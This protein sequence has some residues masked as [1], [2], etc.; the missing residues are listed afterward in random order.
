MQKGGQAKISTG[1]SVAH[2]VYRRMLTPNSVRFVL[3][4]RSHEFVLV[5]WRPLLERT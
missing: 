4:E 3:I 2:G 1:R 5:P